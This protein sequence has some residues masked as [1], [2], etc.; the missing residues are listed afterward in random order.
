MKPPTRSVLGS[1][2]LMVLAAAAQGQQKLN[3]RIPI[4]PDASI[5]IYNLPAATRV[6]GWERDSIAVSGLAP[7][8]T[9]FYLGGSGRIAKL[10]LEPDPKLGP[11]P[12]TGL[13]EVRVPRGARIWVKSAE[14]SIAVEGLSGEADLATVSGSITVSGSL[15]LVTAETLEGS[16]D[17]AGASQLVRVK[18]G[19]GKVTLTRISGDLTV[20]TVAGAVTLVEANP[21][22]ARIET[23]SGAVTYDGLI[24]RR[25]S[26]EIQ[27]H[28]GDVELRVPPSVSAEFD[29]HS[30]EGTVFLALSPKQAWSKPI[31]GRPQF[32]G[33]GGGGAHVMVR[34]FK[35]D[36]RLVGRD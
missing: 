30:I 14:G 15:R 34:S 28:S 29:V 25:S 17:V 16:L 10:G 11:V 8:G 18:T 12:G 3:R 2:V 26:L 31:R 7:A 24:G 6:I 32:F 20:S 23:V 36:I 21:A 35:G 27:T 4:A 33:L 1:A 5:R 13:L 9:T 19:N 22:S